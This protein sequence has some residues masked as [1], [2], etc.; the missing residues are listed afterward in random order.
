MDNS[1]C[2]FYQSDSLDKDDPEIAFLVSNDDIEIYLYSVL[3]QGVYER[4]NY[5][6]Q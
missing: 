1:I 4:D 6:T 5:T 3:C 2:P